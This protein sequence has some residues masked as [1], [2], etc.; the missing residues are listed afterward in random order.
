MK[1]GVSFVG[2]VLGF[3][4]MAKGAFTIIAAE[5]VYAIINDLTT[6]AIGG[7]PLRG[8]EQAID[9]HF[10]AQGILSF[11]M[12]IMYA[13]AGLFD[14]RLFFSTAFLAFNIST[15][16]LHSL[17]MFNGNMSF[18][19][20]IVHLVELVAVSGI[21]FFCIVKDKISGGGK[22]KTA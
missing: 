6:F 4:L 18:E 9:D 17:L 3:L 15:I 13:V 21:M 10:I 22:K 20:S 14:D 16:G 19:K 11:S 2:I 8:A 5:V 12:G 1:F 7:N